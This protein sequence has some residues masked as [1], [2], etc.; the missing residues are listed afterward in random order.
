MKARLITVC[1]TFV[2][3]GPEVRANTILGSGATSCGKWLAEQNEPFLHRG[4]R[5][6]VL[7]YLSGLNKFSSVDFLKN[8]EVDGIAAAIDKYCR[9][10]PLKDMN[11]AA[12]DVARQMI[13]MTK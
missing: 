1:L 11:D 10:N 5:L 3:L 13:R 9:E 6:W 8:F 2:L 12:D 4:R 7:G